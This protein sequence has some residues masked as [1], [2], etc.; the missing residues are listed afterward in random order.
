MEPPSFVVPVHCGS[1]S[2]RREPYSCRAMRLSQFFGTVEKRRVPWAPSICPAPSSPPFGGY[3]VPDAGWNQVNALRPATAALIALL[4]GLALAITGI[5]AMRDSGF[6]STDVLVAVVATMCMTLAL[7]L[8]IQVS[9]EKKDYFDTAV[10]IAAVL[11]L[12]PAFAA[13]AIG[14]GTLVAHAVRPG[15]R[16]WA[17]ALFSTAQAMIVALIAALIL[18]LS[19]WDAGESTFANLR[20]LIALPVVAVISFVLSAVLHSTVVASETRA[21]GLQTLRNSLREDFRAEAFSYA[22]LVTTGILAAV[23]A[24]HVPGALLLLIIPVAATYVTLRHQTRLRQEAERARVMS[25]ANL[26]EAQRLARIGS[27]EWHPE[28]SQWIWSDEVYRIAGLDP[29]ASFPM[30]QDLL[31]I[32][33]PADRERVSE[34]FRQA[35]ATRKPFVIEHRIVRPN[36]S[37]RHV[38]QRGEP[39]EDSSDPLTF[40]G[41]MQDITDRV[42]AE[43]AMRKAAIAAEDAARVRSQLLSMASHDLRTPL[44]AIQGYIEIVV[45]G[46]AGETTEDQ[47]ELLGIAHRNALQLTALVNDLLDLSRIDA[48]RLPLWLQPTPIGA[49]IDR[50]LETVAPLAAEKGLELCGNVPDGTL[51]VNADPDRL[52][53]ILLNLVG[54]A[55]KFTDQ[56][57]ITIAARAD[58]GSVIVDVIDTGIGIPSDQLPQVF[59]EFSQG[60]AEARRR[61]GTGLG[62]AIVRHLVDLHGGAISARSTPGEG[63]TFTLVL[64]AAPTMAETGSTLSATP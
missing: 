33:E 21:P 11:L 60:S 1:T 56:G 53:Q 45:S 13:A 31:D 46:G 9:P 29:K 15:A 5:V 4:L 47:R 20:P 6:D 7:L 14:S 23:V 26:V 19:G 61:G 34:V 10:M 35:L 8:P 48:G 37:T 51:A 12:P 32:V 42:R 24:M 62:L 49:A 54:N 25:D 55:V 58:N 3:G 30:H 22:S 38:Q 43:E 39:R 50:V 17:G 59:E 28:S 40:L 36:G 57:T 27:W 44:T 41:T 16:D 64:P 18:A 52:H 2:S 63:S